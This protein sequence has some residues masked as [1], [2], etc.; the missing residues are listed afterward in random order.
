MP[1]L[2]LNPHIFRAY[3]IRGVAGE[4]FTPAVVERIGRAHGTYLLRRGSSRRPPPRSG[5]SRSRSLVVAVGHDSRPSSQALYDGVIAGLRATGVDVIAVGLAPTPLLS[6]A[7]A[8]WQLDGGI[9]ITAS[10][11]PVRFNGAKLLEAQGLPLSPEAIQAVAA[12]AQTND[13]EHG[14]GALAERDPKPEYLA[15]LRDRFAVARPLTVVADPGNAVATLTGPDA[16]RAIG[17]RVIGLYTE[18]LD[19]FP[20]HIADP[21]EPASMEDLSAAV[22]EHGAD[23]GVAWD[24]DGDRIGVTDERGLRYEADWLV[25]LLARDLLSRHPG[26]PVLVDLKT[27]LGP[28]QDI[29]AHGGR[30]LL[31]RTGYSLLRRRMQEEAI[32]FGGE[33]SGHII[34]AED[35][36]AIDDGVYAA[37]ALAHFLAADPSPLSAHFASIRR[38]VT[39]PE[40]KLPCPDHAKFRIAEAVAHW[41]APRFPVLTIDGARV[42]FG[43]GWA[44]I[45]G[46]NTN[47]YLS[48][49]IEAE[50]RSRY[51][52]I[53]RL[54]WD[55]LLRHPEV[56]LPVG[57]PAPLP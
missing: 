13:F 10:H 39:S 24:G 55:A 9:S 18:L 42:D 47:P 21:Q 14:R 29:R 57:V 28:I 48:V 51:D 22:A 38:F 7:A 56:V 26:A 25:A 11:N 5:R 19:G 1:D 33:A 31:S 37:C 32:L 17:C 41:F 36:Y 34:F 43:D 49:R 4:D 40:I 16:L 46:S 52:A 45:R 23:F 30:P 50:S 20:N 27:S 54:I 44:L 8:A 12:L 6:F 15:L 3:D 53:G 2:M 35:Y